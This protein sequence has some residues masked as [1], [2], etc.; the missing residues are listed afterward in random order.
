MD[1]TVENANAFPS[2]TPLKDSKDRGFDYKDFVVVTNGDIVDFFKE[3]KDKESKVVIELFKQKF[4]LHKNDL[5]SGPHDMSVSKNLKTI[6]SKAVYNL[7]GKKKDEFLKQE[8][9]RVRNKAMFL[10]DKLQ[11]SPRK[12]ALRETLELSEKRNRELKRKL[13][14]SIEEKLDQEL[15][16]ITN[17]YKHDIAR[18]S[19]AEQLYSQVLSKMLEDNINNAK[20]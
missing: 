20:S 11:E 14:S 19:F 13:D 12:E 16:Q 5:S 10:S 8:Y 15:D 18:L 17:D 1:F 3:N 7:R 6:Y 9:I 2:S 4:G